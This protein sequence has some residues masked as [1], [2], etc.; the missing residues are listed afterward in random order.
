MTKNTAFALGLVLLAVVAALFLVLGWEAYWLSIYWVG[1]LL[2]MG[3]GA[4]GVVL[5]GLSGGEPRKVGS[6]VVFGLSALLMAALTCV[7]VVALPFD[8]IWFV[9]L[10]LVIGA[11]TVAAAVVL[12]G[13]A[14]VANA[15][16]Q[17]RNAPR[18]FFDGCCELVASIRFSPAGRSHDKALSALEEDLRY[19]DN[20][21]FTNLDGTIRQRL[22]LLSTAIQDPAFA[23]QEEIRQIRDLIRQR[24]HILHP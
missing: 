5:F 4:V 19:L 17:E 16:T 12:W 13:H 2:V 7:F 15:K 1:F 8:Y 14:A 20:T 9:A 22:E 6:A 10:A 18:S 21:K 3:L 24:Q 11:L 23:A